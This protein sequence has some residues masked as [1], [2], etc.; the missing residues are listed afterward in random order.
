MPRRIGGNPSGLRWRV[1]PTCPQVVHFAFRWPTAHKPPHRHRRRGRSVPLPAGIPDRCHLI[2]GY[3]ARRRPQLPR[4]M[5]THCGIW[6][7]CRGHCRRRT[8]REHH[9][10]RA[11]ASEHAFQRIGFR[12]VNREPVGHPR[13]QYLGGEPA[14]I[15]AGHPL[16]RVCRF[17]AYVS[18]SP[19]PVPERRGHVHRKRQHTA[20]VGQPATG[21]TRGAE[22]RVPSP[23]PVGRQ[24]H[25]PTSFGRMRGRGH[26][27][28]VSPRACD[29]GC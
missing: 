23:R 6:R 20:L 29:G 13:L 9:L 5:R 16:G 19:S 24:A 4:R 26:C 27:R 1:A 22:N 7:W 15:E 12:T 8:R 14:L 28:M 3:A 25:P 11:T 10:G 2:P 21:R 18:A 17:A